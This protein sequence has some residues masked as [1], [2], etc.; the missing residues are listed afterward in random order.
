MRA[1]HD[2]G[3]LAAVTRDLLDL[4]VAAACRLRSDS[5]GAA[6]GALKDYPPADK[7]TQ[8]PLRHRRHLDPLR[9]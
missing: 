1:I 5:L 3:L 2:A 7:P 4:P 8:P 6:A 9:T